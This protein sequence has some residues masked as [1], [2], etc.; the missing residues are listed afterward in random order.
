M[1]DTPATI[2]TKQEDCLVL[3]RSIHGFHMLNA[4]LDMTDEEILD[5]LCAAQDIVTQ[6]MA[7]KQYESTNESTNDVNI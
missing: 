1:R 7:L 4:P 5:L 2:L 6:R 3:L